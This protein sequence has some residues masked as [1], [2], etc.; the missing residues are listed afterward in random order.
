M[1]NKDAHLGCCENV[2]NFHFQSPDPIRCF[3]IWFYQTVYQ[4]IDDQCKDFLTISD[5][6]IY[7]DRKKLPQIV[8]DTVNR[9]DA[10]ITMFLLLLTPS[11]N[12]LIF[13]KYYAPFRKQFVRLFKKG[14]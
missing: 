10:V 5:I 4:Q 1:I 6:D 14:S 3:S 12:F 8:F 11:V 13:C 7:P 9:T 2:K